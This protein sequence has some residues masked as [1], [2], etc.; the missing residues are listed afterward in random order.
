LFQ[1]LQWGRWCGELEDLLLEGMDASRQLRPPL[2][3][4]ASKASGSLGDHQGNDRQN[5]S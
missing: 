1:D 4:R 3:T 2:V 5:K